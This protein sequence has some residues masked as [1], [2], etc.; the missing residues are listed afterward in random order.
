MKG[1]HAYQELARKK[2]QEELILSHLPLVKHVVGRLAIDLPRGVDVENLESAGTLGLVE[3]AQAFDPTRNVQFKTFA[4][5]RIRGA[6]L[7]E[8]RRNSPL[9]QQQQERVTL[10]RKAIAR[11]LPAQAGPVTVEQLARETGLSEDE[12]SDTLQALRFARALGASELEGERDPLA[13]SPSQPLEDA[14]RRQVLA[15]AIEALPVQERLVVTL[16]YKE[17]LRLKEISEV[18]Q[19]SES[20][21][22]RLLN[23]ALLALHGRLATHQFQK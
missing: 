16:Y 7:D 22:S 9:S 1:L 12:T 8:L 18:M 23:S 15:D 17:D 21:I 3:A 20:R 13:E 11:L 19:L 6:I 14:E 5:T 2:Q 4:Y 10:V